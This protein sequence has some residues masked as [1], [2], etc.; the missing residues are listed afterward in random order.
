MDFEKVL[1]TQRVAKE[2]FPTPDSPRRTA[3][4]VIEIA[5]FTS[6]K[7]QKKFG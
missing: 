1:K 5:L 2:V 7:Q 3:L 6:N 4:N